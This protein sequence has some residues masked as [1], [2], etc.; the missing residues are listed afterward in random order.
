MWNVWPGLKYPEY[1]PKDWREPL[2]PLFVLKTSDKDV[3]FTGQI[4]TGLVLQVEAVWRT[5]SLTLVK[6]NDNTYDEDELLHLYFCTI[7]F[8]FRHF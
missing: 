4:I 3:T 7:I 5:G 6:I 8:I 2:D 1:A